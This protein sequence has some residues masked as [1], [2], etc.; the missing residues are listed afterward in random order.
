VRTVTNSLG[1]EITAAD[2]DDYVPPAYRSS[3]LRHPL[4]AD[5]DHPGCDKCWCDIDETDFVE[6]ENFNDEPVPYT[7]NKEA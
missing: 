3:L 5:P 4:C 6:T 2:F 1:D 7:S